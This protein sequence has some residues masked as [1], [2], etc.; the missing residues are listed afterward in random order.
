MAL[1]ERIESFDADP[2]GTEREVE[3]GTV[4][5]FELQGLVEL[6]VLPGWK[7]SK[8]PVLPVSLPKVGP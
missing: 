2:A 3:S 4:V 1:R 8:A 7:D 5:R 6:P